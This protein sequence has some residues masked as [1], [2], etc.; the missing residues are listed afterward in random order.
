MCD[1]VGAWCTRLTHGFCTRCQRFLPSRTRSHYR[2]S[3]RQPL[4]ATPRH[5]KKP[6]GS[7]GY[8]VWGAAAR[9]SRRWPTCR[10]TGWL[11]ARLQ[12]CLPGCLAAWLAAWL[13]VCFLLGCLAA[14]LL[15]CLTACGCL[16][17]PG[18]LAAWLPGCLAAGLLGCLVCLAAWLAWNS[19]LYGLAIWLPGLSGSSCLLGLPGLAA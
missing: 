10:L 15:D 19:W 16:W 7:L 3:V 18:C 8:A 14:W 5:A 11:G 17:L 4:R 12:L 2:A 13:L 1:S 9:G 6:I